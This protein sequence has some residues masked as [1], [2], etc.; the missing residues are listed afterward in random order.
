ARARAARPGLGARLLAMGLA[1]PLE[2]GFHTPRDLALLPPRPGTIEL[3]RSGR[4]VDGDRTWL[5]AV[6]PWNAR[7]VAGEEAWLLLENRAFEL[8]WAAHSGLHDPPLM[9]LRRRHAVLKCALDLASVMALSAGEYAESAA[10]RVAWARPRWDRA[11]S[12]EPP[13][14]AALEWRKGQAA[15]LEPDEAAVER[16]RTVSAWVATWRHLAGVPGDPARPFASVAR[17]ARRARLRRRLREALLPDALVGHLRVPG[18]RIRHALAGTPRH[19]LN[20]AAAAHLMFEASCATPTERAGQGIE[21]LG[22]D[23]RLLLRRLGI[24]SDSSADLVMAWDRG[25]LDGQRTEDWA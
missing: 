14:D 6:P 3:R 7:D 13:W 19:R 4:V 9:K 1:A 16:L 15:A 17:V 25:L 10:A 23:L 8:L 22:R 18:G 5:D 12:P 2:V 24:A 20:A 11:G 21:A